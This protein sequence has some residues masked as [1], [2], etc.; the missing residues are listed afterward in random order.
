[1][2]VTT[3]DI[4]YIVLSICILWITTFSCWLLYYAIAAA[5][6]LRH[7]QKKVTEKVA[8]IEKTFSSL[9]SFVEKSVGS[10]GLITEGM[11]MAMKFAQNRKKKKSKKKD[12]DDEE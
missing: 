6:D 10:V 11:K 7:L 3:K 8:A 1:M 5:R 2:I 9:H 12:E 4:F